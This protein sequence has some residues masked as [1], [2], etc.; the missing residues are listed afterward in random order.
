MGVDFSHGEAHF[1]YTSF[2]H[3]RKKLASLIDVDY[4]K[5]QGCGGKRPWS[6]VDDPL[7]PFL[8]RSDCDGK[9]CPEESRSVAAR[10][11]ELMDNKRLRYQLK[12]EPWE[13]VLAGLED[14]AAKGEA[15]EWG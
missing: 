12:S 3:F 8:Y 7:A 5:M 2:M 9:L 6:E 10:F 11:R 15:F 13:E 4:A 14:A 1:G